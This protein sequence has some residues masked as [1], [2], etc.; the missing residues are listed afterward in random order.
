LTHVSKKRRESVVHF[1]DS[2]V[3]Y[4]L[5][6]ENCFATCKEAHELLFTDCFLEKILT[7]VILDVTL[8]RWDKV[9]APR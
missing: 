1:T 5:R 3:D 6:Y 2:R 8:A 4:F 7:E 9:V